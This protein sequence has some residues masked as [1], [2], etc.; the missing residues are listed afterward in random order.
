MTRKK[1]YFWR[2]QT[3]HVKNRIL[4]RG[5]LT[6]MQLWHKVYLQGQATFNNPKLLR[7]VTYLRVVSLIKVLTVVLTLITSWILIYFHK[8]IKHLIERWLVFS[9]RAGRIEW[10]SKYQT[11]VISGKVRIRGWTVKSAATTAARCSVGNNI[12]KQNYWE[13]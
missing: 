8:Q 6:S 4:Q 3:N 11:Y 2:V 13:N 10:I 12:E 9:Q 1:C 7:F 5:R